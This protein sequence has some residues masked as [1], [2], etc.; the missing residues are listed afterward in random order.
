MGRLLWGR[1]YFNKVKTYQIRDYLSPDGFFVGK[2]FNVTPAPEQFAR[3]TDFSSVPQMYP[4]AALINDLSL[5]VTLT[6]HCI[7]TR[8]QRG[9]V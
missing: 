6:A 7:N 3:F 5:R 4:G 8:P 9:W 2:T 1:R